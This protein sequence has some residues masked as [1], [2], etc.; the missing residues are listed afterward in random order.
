MSM[1][2]AVDVELFFHPHERWT[3]DDAR[4]YT[5]HAVV[6]PWK[7]SKYAAGLITAAP[8]LPTMSTRDQHLLLSCIKER[9]ETKLG[10]GFIRFGLDIV[11]N[12]SEPV[13]EGGG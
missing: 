10:V 1:A 13:A 9:L 7:G 11:V 6:S 8:P 4:A 12:G 5:F 2:Q 3:T